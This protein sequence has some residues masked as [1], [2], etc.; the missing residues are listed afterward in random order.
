MEQTK[1]K[2]V[3]VGALLKGQYGDYIRLGQN[4]SKNPKYNY[5][6]KIMVKNSEGTKVLDVLNGSVKLSDPR[7]FKNQDGSERN[8]P[9][10]LRFE[11]LVEDKSG[12]EQA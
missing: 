6:V 10:S 7:K 9:E 5:D 2:W 11:L 12:S 4:N 8:I 3:K 1:K